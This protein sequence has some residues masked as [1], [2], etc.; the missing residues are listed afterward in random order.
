[1]LL[2]AGAVALSVVLVSSIA[3]VMASLNAAFRSQIDTQ[4]GT[5]EA[6][7]LPVSGETFD[8]S[9]LGTAMSWDGV[10]LAVPRLQSTLSLVIQ[11]PELKARVGSY[12]VE[13]Q[14][15]AV[16][17]FVNGVDP[18]VEFSSRP[19]GLIQGRLP[20]S[21]DEIVI[22][23]RVAQRLSWSYAQ[24]V[25]SREGVD[26]FADPGA[27]LNRAPVQPGVQA[28]DEQEMRAI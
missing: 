18:D 8:A 24:Q 9:L 23:M 6:R 5:A 4:I 7:L 11:Q 10:E 21:L 17:A 13:Q 16:N 19:I 22:D 3:C 14:R 26:L 12:A 20:Q 25:R 15:Y 2:L 27:Y 1:M 28:E